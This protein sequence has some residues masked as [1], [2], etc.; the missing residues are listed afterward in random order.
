MNN[1]FSFGLPRLENFSNRQEG[2]KHRNL[3]LTERGKRGRG[4]LRNPTFTDGGR[5]SPK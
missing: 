3:T 1:K 2:E 4:G 5:V